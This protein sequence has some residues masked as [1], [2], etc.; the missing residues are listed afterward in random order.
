MNLALYFALVFWHFQGWKNNFFQSCSKLPKN[1]FRTIKILFFFQIFCN[2]KDG[3]VGET[4]SGK[5]QIFFEPF[6]NYLFFLTS[7]RSPI[8]GEAPK[9]FKIFPLIFLATNFSIKGEHNKS[10]ALPFKKTENGHR[11][12]QFRLGTIL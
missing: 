8:I 12:L 10:W 1:D 4:K 2:Y 7:L 5:F 9:M 6:P 3:W 11:A